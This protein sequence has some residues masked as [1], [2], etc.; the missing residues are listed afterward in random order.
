MKN[1]HSFKHIMKLIVG[2]I[3]TDHDAYQTEAQKV[4]KTYMHKHSDVTSFFLK[5]DNTKQDCLFDQETFYS[6]SR[7]PV[8][9]VQNMVIKSLKFMEVML[10]KE[11]WEYMLRTN[12]SSV[13]NW[14]IVLTI[15]SNNRHCDVIANNVSQPHPNAW[16]VNIIPTGCGMF[17]SRKAVVGIVDEWKK[18]PDLLNFQHPDDVMI[19]IL[20]ARAG[21]TTIANYNYDI[22]L[23]YMGTNINFF[24]LRCKMF[25]EPIL[26]VCYEIPMMQKWINSWYAL[27]T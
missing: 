4:W 7:C 15:L 26:R 13:F 22:V 10:K 16:P 1:Y 6:T 19:G 24:H 18:D 12:L 27:R 25:N 5:V 17:L 2:I 9:T 3:A 8:E 14:N 11:S 23:P 20:L 21:F